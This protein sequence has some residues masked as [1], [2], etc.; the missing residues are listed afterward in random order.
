LI[1]LLVVIA[2]I[3]VLIGLL[4]PA[5]QK[6]RE[7]ASRMSCQN[8]L[9]Q[10]GLAVHNYHDTY[11]KLPP[12]YITG[13]G[14]PNWAVFLLPYIEMDNVYK[15]FNLNWQGM[16]YRTANPAI[17]Q[18]A[19][20]M[21]F[22]PSRRSPPQLSLDNNNRSFSGVQTYNIPGT[23]SDYAMA[24]GSD[25]ANYYNQGAM[26]WAGDISTFDSRP[27][28]H[29]IV[30]TGSSTSFATISDGLT[31]QV[32]VGDKHVPP[33]CYGYGG[34]NNSTPRINCGDGPFFNDDSPWWHARLMGRQVVRAGVFI[35]RPLANGP[36]DLT[37]EV[38]AKFGS[39]HAGVCQFCFF[40]G[41]VRA[42]SNSTAIDILTR[43]VMPADGQVLGNF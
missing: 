43:L 32:F 37:G 6:V 39:N 41:S 4:L 31:N 5:V 36:T 33:V 40:D 20:K 2:I 22:C 15:G 17:R 28:V 1:E 25:G 8:N 30:S 23:L 11:N 7:A 21:F 35:D 3:A 12:L 29:T 38:F 27:G 24:S 34:S 13:N 26:R 10:W 9:K 16:Y 18:G 19:S 14:T 42:V